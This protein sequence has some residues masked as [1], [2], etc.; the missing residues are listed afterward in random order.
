MLMASQTRSEGSFG[1]PKMLREEVLSTV[2]PISVLH[3]TLAVNLSC[4]ALT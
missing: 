2:S 1:I 3:L 4:F